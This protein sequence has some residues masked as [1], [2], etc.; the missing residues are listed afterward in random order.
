MGQIQ[1]ERSRDREK[2]MKCPYLQQWVGSN[3]RVLAKPYHPS[4]SE[5]QEYC[6][7]ENYTKCPLIFKGTRYQDEVL[8]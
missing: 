6:A 5:L 3:C 8:G 4:I 7:S 1:V 2:K